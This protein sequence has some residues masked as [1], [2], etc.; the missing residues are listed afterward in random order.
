MQFVSDGYKISGGAIGLDA[1]DAIIR[2]GDGTSEGG[3]FKAT[4]GAELTG[5]G[6]LDKT[7]LGTLILTG[8][9]SYTGGTRVSSGTLQLGGGG[10]SGSIPG[11]VAVDGT[12]AFDRSDAVTFGGVISG[13]GLVQQIGSGT[14]ILTADSSAF[15]GQTQI[16]AGTLEVD[17]VLGG[18][19]EVFAG[20]RLTG[21]GQ[22]GTTTN[23]GVIAPGRGGI[24]TLTIAG[25][26]TGAGGG[27]EIEAVLGGDASPADRLAIAGATSG[28]TPVKVANLG[29]MGAQTQRGIQVVQ[30]GG[31]S[32]GQFILANG[33]YSIA[34]QQALV[35]GAY[36][37]VLQRDQ[38]DGGWYLRSSL[39][40]GPSGRDTPLYQPGVP[41]YEAYANTLLSLSGAATLRQRVGD[42]RY[43]ATDADHNGVWGRVESTTN[44]TQPMVSTSGLHQ[45]IDSWKAQ[46]GVDR[47]LTGAEDGSHLVGG[48]TAHIGTADTRV[49]SIY[50][51]GDIDTKAYGVG[52]T[53]TWY[54]PQG[55]YVDGQA[56]ATWF[57]SDLSST[58]AGRLADGQDGHGYGLSLEAGKAF[59]VADSLS[60]TPQAQ[61]SYAF[62]SFGAFNDR[63][64]ARVDSDRGESLQGRIGLALDHQRSWRDAAGQTRQLS[65]YGLLNAKYE[66][67]D[68]TR[69][70]V[71]GTP[72]DSRQGR[73]WGG[74]GAGGNYAWGNGRYAV[75]GEASA[76]TDL[77]S[78]GDSYA[79]TG[80]VGFRVRF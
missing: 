6:Q 10:T 26:Y 68:G 25:D 33:A 57:D 8:T 75:Y 2:V 37:Y 27:L 63:F 44:P 53:M 23:R 19:A 18:S 73:T 21:V 72:I 78:F 65:L 52:A 71:S 31:A 61:L 50:G 4:L 30:V 32:N 47:V 48:L 39:P 59:A 46:F 3:A 41:V 43:D 22:V 14:T 1:G 42:R 51:G 16:Q 54:G 69:V 49:S 20:G 24:G 34:E 56:Q 70:L 35:A 28:V 12:L 62:T 5:A 60:V 15:I 67:L 11:D 64:D 79:V 66:F 13:S 58:L 7:D 77:S 74:L 80:T 55:A 17:G 36:G 9:N 38:A 40:D 29:G 45:D 76:D